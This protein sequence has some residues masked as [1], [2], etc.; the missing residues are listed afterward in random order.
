MP[1]LFKQKQAA[2]YLGV[3]ERTLEKW[4][5]DGVGPR[6]TKV[7]RGV[8]YPEA[9]LV[10]FVEAGLRRSTSEVAQ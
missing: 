6:Y 1:T 7:G 8:R 2:D 10:E 3:S 9:G 5:L 4:R